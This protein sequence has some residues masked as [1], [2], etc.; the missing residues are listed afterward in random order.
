[1]REQCALGD[2]LLDLYVRAAIP[3]PKSDRRRTSR[4]GLDH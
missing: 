2:D 4:K 1:M 3:V